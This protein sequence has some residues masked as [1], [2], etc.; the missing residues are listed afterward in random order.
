MDMSLSKLRVLVLDRETWR[1]AVHRVAESDMTE[2][3]NWND[4]VII[5][6]L[7]FTSGCN[8]R[9]FFF[10]QAVWSTF[11]VRGNS[12]DFPCPVYTSKLKKKASPQMLLFTKLFFISPLK[13]SLQ[14][15]VTK[16]PQWEKQTKGKVNWM[17]DGTCLEDA[18]RLSCCPTLIFPGPFHDGILWSLFQKSVLP[19]NDHVH[20]MMIWCRSSSLPSEK[21]R[22]NWKQKSCGHVS[23]C[24][25]F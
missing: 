7:L 1:A 5:L 12:D 15:L 23:S 8:V 25:H 2:G 18:S 11:L 19:R 6:A 22:W 20:N 17:D 10:Y 24:H 14:W 13:S 4:N 16:T 3:L 21:I 9:Y